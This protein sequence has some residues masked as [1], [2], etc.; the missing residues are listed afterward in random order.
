MLHAT[1]PS[2]SH[3]PVPEGCTTPLPKQTLIEKSNNS[4]ITDTE[5][6]EL[7]VLRSRGSMLLF[8]QAIGS[9]QETILDKKVV[10]PF[11]L[12]FGNAVSPDRAIKYWEPI[13]DATIPFCKQLTPALIGGLNN[14]EKA[15]EVISNFKSLVEATKTV[16]KSIFDKFASYV[17][18]N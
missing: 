15:R 1:T 9:C 4:N 2:S 3:S 16:N 5:S 14:A 8:V 6:E 7:G 12:S 18:E 13:I 10:N 17:L 11:R